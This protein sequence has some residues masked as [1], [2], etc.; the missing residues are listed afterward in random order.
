MRNAADKREALERDIAA[1]QAAN[2]QLE[3]EAAAFAESV[4]PLKACREQRAQWVPSLPVGS[5]A[6]H[7]CKILLVCRKLQNPASRAPPGCTALAERIRGG[8]RQVSSLQSCLQGAP[9]EAER[10]QGAGGGA[11]GPPAGAAQPA[12]AAA[13]PLPHG[14]RLRAGRQGGAA[15]GHPA[16]PGAHLQAPARPGRP[17]EGGRYT[18]CCP[19]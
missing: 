18:F 7:V 10:R 2:V 14:Q 3:H 6:P 11:G 1:T 9:A 4:E 12:D 19:M 15:A 17:S 8:L 16:R 13:G 5:R